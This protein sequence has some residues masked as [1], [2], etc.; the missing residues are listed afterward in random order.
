M[1]LKALI[2]FVLIVIPLSFTSEAPQKLSSQKFIIL[3]PSYNNM[4][5]CKA[6]KEASLKNFQSINSK[7]IETQKSPDRK[8]CSQQ[9][10]AK[11]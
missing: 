10:Q 1:K 3:I 4:A 7:Y 9:I 2:L 6:I 5:W 8:N 11:L